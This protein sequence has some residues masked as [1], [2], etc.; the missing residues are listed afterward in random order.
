MQPIHWLIVLIVVDIP[1]FFLLGKVI[2]GSWAGFVECIYYEMV[3]D[4]WSL[5]KG[6]YHAD[7]VAELKLSLWIAGCV[8]LVLGELWLLF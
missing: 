1:I 5:I 7:F 8:G 4:I 2:F 6:D 3:P